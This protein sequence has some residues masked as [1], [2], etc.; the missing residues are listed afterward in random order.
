MR[1]NRDLNLDSRD[2]DD[3]TLVEIDWKD[4]TYRITTNQLLEIFQQLADLVEDAEVNCE[5]ELER[6]RRRSNLEKINVISSVHKT[7]K[8]WCD[9]VNLGLE[10][11]PIDSDSEEGPT[12]EVEWKKDVRAVKRSQ[13]VDLFEHMA[14]E[15]E[16]SERMSGRRSAT[17]L[18]R[19]ARGTKVRPFQ[20][21][22]SQATHQ[23]VV[24]FCKI[25]EDYLRRL[26]NQRA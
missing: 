5:R 26:Q 20:I 1:T 9:A 14:L 7:V 8:S 16:N 17:L 24:P 2:A 18:R 6:A 21:Q 3:E 19:S 4:N 25:I 23:A 13:L 15:I 22:L 10:D 11:T 12:I